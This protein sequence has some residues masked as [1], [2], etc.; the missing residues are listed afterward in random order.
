[1]S[2]HFGFVCSAQ[3]KMWRRATGMP[4]VVAIF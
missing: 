1:M 2:Q 4:I 3:R